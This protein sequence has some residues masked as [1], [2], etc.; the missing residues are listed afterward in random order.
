M[1][2][3]TDV[4]FFYIGPCSSSVV[5]RELSASQASAALPGVLLARCATG[6]KGCKVTAQQ[7]RCLIAT[8]GMG[9]WHR[10]QQRC[11]YYELGAMVYSAAP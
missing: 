4:I 8:T 7:V 1:D 2:N 5:R 3:S 10:L 6:L 11:M 9:L